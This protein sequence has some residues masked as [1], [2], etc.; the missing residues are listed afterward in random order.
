MRLGMLTSRRAMMEREKAMDAA[1]NPGVSKFGDC[2][3]S[4]N[5]KTDKIY[6]SNIRKINSEIKRMQLQINQKMKHF[7]KNSAVLNHDPLILVERPPSPDVVKRKQVMTQY[8]ELDERGYP[9]VDEDDEHRPSYMRKL[10][11]KARTPSTLT[12]IDA[13]T[14][15]SRK[16]KNVW[17]GAVD[18]KAPPQFQSTVRPFAKLTRREISDL[19]KG[20]EF[21]KPKLENSGLADTDDR[22]SRKTL[23]PK[24]NTPVEESDESDF[25]DTF[26]PFITQMA[27]LKDKKNS[28]KQEKS[29]AEI[30]IR[31]TESPS[32]IKSQTT[33]VLQTG[34]TV[35]FQSPALS[36]PGTKKKSTVRKTKTTATIVTY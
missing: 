21:H 30:K 3:V 27:E 6:V 33:P 5:S 7:V 15:K 4:M 26:T 11:S 1:R 22:S 35:R 28:I 10:R 25:E 12:T 20:L 34:R 36:V 29:I 18:E 9:P 16:K 31:A 8:D 2:L 17:E 13:F 24:K 19:Q 32:S 14:V 23:S